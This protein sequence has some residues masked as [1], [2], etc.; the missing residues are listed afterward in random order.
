MLDL[1]MLPFV[2]HPL[3]ELLEA[4]FAADIGEERIKLRKKGVVYATD[5]QAVVQP[6]E[7]FICLAVQRVD[8]SKNPECH[9]VVPEI[10]QH[11]FGQQRLALSFLPLDS[12]EYRC[13]KQ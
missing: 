9:C 5:V 8:V 4:L 2:F 1:E 10:S 12:I 11:L 7:G 3:H 13:H 6:L